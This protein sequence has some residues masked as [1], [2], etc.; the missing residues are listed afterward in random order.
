MLDRDQRLDLAARAA[1]L[2]YVGGDTQDQIA[3]KLNVSRPGAQRLV[4]L[5]R[6]AN[7]IKVRIDHPIAVCMVLAGELRRRFGLD[8]CEVVPSDPDGREEDLR[9]LAVGGADWIERFVSRESRIVIALGTGR[10]L[11]AA[12]EMLPAI[13][14]PQ[15]RFV[16]LLGNIARDGSTNPFDA[17]MHLAD[18]TGGMRFLLP[19]MVVAES[20]EQRDQVLNQKVYRLITEVV[21]TA[22][23]GFVGIAPIERGAP[24][25][26]DGFISD[27]ELEE[28][29]GLG[30]VGEI[31]GWTFDEDGR[32]LLSSINDRVTSLPLQHLPRMPVIAV[33]GGAAK[34]SAIRAALR[35][36]WVTGL[37]TDE[38]AARA[39]LDQV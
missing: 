12:V 26:K 3:A 31:L 2:Y 30:A 35:G 21:E 17:V 34:A 19:A 14:R 11:R 27:A 22:E 20:V 6:D 16:S 38:A 36:R 25:H 8:L 13:D 18:K 33:A 32:L 5:A 39:V 4:A 37:I 28:L 15:H 23:V 9:Y 10:T 24:L 29:L 7:L 1:W